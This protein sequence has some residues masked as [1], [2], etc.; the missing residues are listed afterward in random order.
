MN[1][2]INLIFRALNSFFLAGLLAL[3]AAISVLSFFSFILKYIRPYESNYWVFNVALFVF[4]LVWIL[5]FA[6]F[7]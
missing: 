4:W 6:Y 7:I 5:C 2:L 3:L 1:Q